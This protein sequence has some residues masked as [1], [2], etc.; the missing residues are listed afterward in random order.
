MPCS[1]CHPTFPASH[2]QSPPSSFSKE[3]QPDQLTEFHY[4]HSLLLP[5]LLPLLFT[6]YYIAYR[7]TT[8][9]YRTATASLHRITA[10]PP[11]HYIAP[12]T[13]SSLRIPH[14]RTP[15][16]NLH[17]YHTPPSPSLPPEKRHVTLH[18]SILCLARV[19]HLAKSATTPSVHATQWTAEEQP[20]GPRCINASNSP[21]LT[22][23]FS[24][25]LLSRLYLTNL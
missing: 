3:A 24:T 7:I 17:L 8:S 18:Y 20:L 5:K 19:A 4:P 14:Y 15:R 21:T 6:A 22:H 25:S 1:R 12:H 13:S 11:H 9:H 16:F 23:R 2:Y 10:P